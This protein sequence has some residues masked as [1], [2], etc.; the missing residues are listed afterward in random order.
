MATEY[1][2]T[3]IDNPFDPFEQFEDWFLFDMEKGYNTCGYLA[4]IAHTSPDLSDEENEEEN[5]RAI[6]EILKY[7]PT[8]LYLR[9]EKGKFKKPE[10]SDLSVLLKEAQS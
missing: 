7:D 8:G 2:L 4:R 1:R 5:N 6:T 9:V 3:T 10:T